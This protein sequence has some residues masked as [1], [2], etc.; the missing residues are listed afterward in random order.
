[1]SKNKRMKKPTTTKNNLSE[2]NNMKTESQQPKFNAGDRVVM[3]NRKD[4]FPS[5]TVIEVCQMNCFYLYKIEL[6]E[7]HQSEPYIFFH[8][9]FFYFLTFQ[10][11]TQKV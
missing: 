2:N 6:D 5:G 1:M 3:M 9:L 8:Y 4:G 11:S 10:L 7:E